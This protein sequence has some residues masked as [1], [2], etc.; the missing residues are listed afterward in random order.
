MTL[1]ALD[2]QGAAGVDPILV[3]A[4]ESS[5]SQISRFLSERYP[6]LRVVSEPT[7]LA[8]IA[9]A[10][11]GFHR[12]VLVEVDDATA[13]LAAALAGIRRACGGATRLLACCHPEQEHAGMRAVSHGADDY[14]VLPLDGEEFDRALG[15]LSPEV[16]SS[17]GGASTAVGPSQVDSLERVTKIFDLLQA[18]PTRLLHALADFALESVPARGLSIVVD[19]TVHHVG[20]AVARPVL[21]A[22]IEAG[23]A[24]TGQ[25]LLGE[26]SGRA[27]EAADM[28]LL[29]MLAGLM[30][31]AIAYSAQM[32]RYQS[33]AMTDACTELPNRRYLN[34]RL[35]EIL[36][37]SASHRYPVSLLLFDVDD[38]KSYND[39]YGHSVGDQI[40]R[41]MGT[42]FRRQCRQHDIVARFG[43]DE[44][45]VVFWDPAG[46]R[47]PGSRHPD[48]AMDVLDRVQTSLR[49][50]SSLYFGS[51][52]HGRLTISGGLA[53]YPWDATT[54]DSL[55]DRADEAL[56]EAKRAGKNRV[57]AIGA[58]SGDEA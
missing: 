55:I 10:A 51:E 1:T 36:A 24:L 49:E 31:R 12:A 19:G 45:A 54:R 8:G 23:G 11:S 27:Y 17:L 4:S 18:E 50:E 3:V 34:A 20:E 14:L 32:R 25:L 30:G 56:L 47:I 43:G 15:V 37:T 46:P 52:M 53:T 41:G 5:R 28:D 39:A 38:F 58:R 35:D 42:L 13:D 21:T 7:V 6:S 9:E 2:I 57:I 26:P 48:C 29:K 44:F 40:L 16:A 22:P 33:M